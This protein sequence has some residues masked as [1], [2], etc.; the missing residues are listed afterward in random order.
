MS[1]ESIIFV[2]LFDHNY[3]VKGVAMVQSFLHYNPK[4]SIK[5]LCLDV[6]TNIILNDLFQ[7]DSRIELYTLSDLDITTINSILGN[8]TYQEFC[9]S[10]ASIFSNFAQLKFNN[11]VIYL[12]SDIYFF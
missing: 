6:Q 11:S 7:E 12:D 9:W 4:S 10:L 5:I 1:D 8:R 2:T 3:A